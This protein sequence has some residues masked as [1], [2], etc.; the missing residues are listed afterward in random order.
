MQGIE[1]PAEC[2]E[3]DEIQ[4]RAVGLKTRHGAVIAGNALFV[5][6]PGHVEDPVKIGAIVDGLAEAA[7]ARLRPRS[8]GIRGNP[9]QV[10][11]L[12][13]QIEQE[14]RNRVSD[15]GDRIAV[16]LFPQ[17][18]SLGLALKPVANNRFRD[19]SRA[20][21]THGRERRS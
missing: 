7:P 19:R 16:E 17:D 21:S 2:R 4:C 10:C 12:I 20:A 1:D 18:R 14:Q 15:N 6:D 8:N 11:T 3:P 13:T 9:E 5:G